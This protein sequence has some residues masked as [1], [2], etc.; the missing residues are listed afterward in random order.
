MTASKTIS[1]PVDTQGDYGVYAN[2]FRVM[3]DGPDAVLDFCVYSESENQART[4]CR[5][6]VPPSFLKVVL[7]RLQ[8]ATE[9]PDQSEASPLY[10]VPTT[11]G[12]N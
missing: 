1:C 11:Q 9:I 6:R 7:G 8:E 10:L 5:V 12:M 4:V 2:A 3:Q